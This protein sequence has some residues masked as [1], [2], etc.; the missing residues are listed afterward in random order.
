MATPNTIS[1]RA[2]LA[3]LSAANLFAIDTREAA[4][5]FHAKSLDGEKF[6]NESVKGKAVLIEFWATWCPYCKRDQPAID[7]MV[8][9]Y[10]PQGLIV[11]AV[12]VREPR[13]KVERY[14]QQSPRA[15]KIVMMEDSNLAAMFAAKKFPFYVLIDQDGKIAGTHQGEAREAGLKRLLRKVISSDRS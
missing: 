1:R 11:L 2:A 14:L 12:D 3:M 5:K 15:C 4:P 13:K 8:E 10:G 6:N 7:A 9:E